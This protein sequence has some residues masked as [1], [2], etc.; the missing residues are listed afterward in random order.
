M[1]PPIVG[2]TPR[3]RPGLG[4]SLLTGAVLGLAAC[5]GSESSGEASSAPAEAAAPAAAP[6]TAP[7]GTGFIMMSEGSQLHLTEDSY[8]EESDC[9]ARASARGDAEEF[10]GCMEVPASAICIQVSEGARASDRWWECYVQEEACEEANAGHE[11]I[12]ETGGYLREVIRACGETETA[13]VFAS[14]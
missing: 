4:V 10:A 3:R 5:G 8:L 2:T 11:M 13:S 7:L 14:M 12:R 9:T 1:N 6:T